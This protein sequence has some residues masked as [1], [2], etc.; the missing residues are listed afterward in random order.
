MN[1]AIS[2]LSRVVMDAVDPQE[3]I[4]MANNALES[5]HG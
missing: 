4:L 1:R 5:L 2:A 3:V